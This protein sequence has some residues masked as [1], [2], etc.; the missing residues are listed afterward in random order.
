M[1]SRSAP[2]SQRANVRLCLIPDEADVPLARRAPGWAVL[3]AG[4]AV[5]LTV[6]ATA[7]PASAWWPG[8]AFS[9][10]AAGGYP[11]GPGPWVL[12]PSQ[13][14]RPDYRYSVP[15]GAPL[16]YDDP[17]SGTTYC[18][19]QTTG[20][21]FA[22]GY[23]PPVALAVGPVPPPPPVAPSSRLDSMAPPA[24]GV[25]L[26]RL[27]QGS[28]A[29]INGVPIGLSE[30]VGIHAL[31]P[32]RHQV[33]LHVSGK[34]TTHTVEVRSHRILTVTPAGVVATEP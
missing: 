16:S 27:P 13:R 25:L 18:W 31:A 7:Q 21:Y 23:A 1:T 12:F 9:P 17:A 3:L 30:G 33:V 24:S 32:G 4:L 14:P 29:T 2:N 28:Q 8:H 11:W 34:Q 15:P 19:S 6:C 20:F 5:V 10:R 26:F 22:C